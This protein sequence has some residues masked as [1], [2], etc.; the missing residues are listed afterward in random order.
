MTLIISWIGVDDK[1][2]GKSI[3]SIY[4]AS[5][6]R[7]S[8]GKEGFY[9]YGIKVFGSTRHPEIFGFCGD[10]S[11]P[12]LVF[13]QVIPQIDSSLLIGI[14]DSGET[15]N[16]KLFN[17]I[18]SSFSSY[19]RRFLSGSFSII[20]ATRAENEFKFYKTSY[21]R[22]KGLKNEEVPLPNFST[23]VFVG[24]SGKNDFDKNWLLWDRKTHN[25]F[26][27]SRSAYHCLN[28]TLK[29]SKDPSVGGL[30]QIVGL[31]RYGNARIFGIIEG[32]K[33]IIYGKESSTDINST[34]IE[35]RNE[36]FERMNPETL[37]IFDG[38]QRQPS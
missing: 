33:K 38:A 16:C 12:S 31:Y 7:Y 6:S 8:W 24:G 15:K 21:N 29:E 10:V 34:M 17:Y 9:D 23:P 26:R 22:D 20:H 28:K 32:G 13:G 1:K 37:R 3:G 25:D 27:T 4:I 19:P 36:N 35:W 14:D 11:F 18:E 2:E 5:D 30:A